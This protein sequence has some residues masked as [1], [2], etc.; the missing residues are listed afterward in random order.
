LQDQAPPLEAL[1]LVG[2]A[3]LLHLPDLAGHG[4]LLHV[5]EPLVHLDDQ[6]GQRGPDPVCRRLFVG[7]AVGVHGGVRDVDQREFI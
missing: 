1:V 3:G 7:P 6:L 2:E 4:A 5:A